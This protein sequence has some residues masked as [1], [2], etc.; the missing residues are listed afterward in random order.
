[1]ERQDELN[2]IMLY[3]SIDVVLHALLEIN[4][5][6]KNTRKSCENKFIYLTRLLKEKYF[7]CLQSSS[8]TLL[9]KL[10]EETE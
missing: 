9:N 3:L 8:C 6:G 2:I 4:G 5:G 1:M 10:S 7:S